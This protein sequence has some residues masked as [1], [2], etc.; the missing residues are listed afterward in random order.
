MYMG[1]ALINFIHLDSQ[2]KEMILSW[3]NDD[4][5][6][7]W[8]YTN[9]NITLTEHL[10]FIESL[11]NN[12]NKKFFLVNDGKKSIG[13]IN[14]TNITSLSLHMGIYANPSIK[15]VGSILL[16]IIIQYSFEVFKVLKIYAEVFSENKKAYELYER[17]GFKKYDEKKVYEKR[18]YCMELKKDENR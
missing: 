11:K 18:V 3:R 12:D 15:G 13:I 2:Q 17:Y 6:K 8:M 14:F 5:V 16:E 1:Y 7:K 9:H 10:T 4:R